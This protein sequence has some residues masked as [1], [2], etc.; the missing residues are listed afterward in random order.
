LRLISHISDSS[1]AAAEDGGDAFTVFWL[2][3]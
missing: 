1:P 3:R 2:G